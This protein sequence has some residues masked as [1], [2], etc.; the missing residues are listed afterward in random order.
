MITMWIFFFDLQ[1]V[2]EIALDPLRLQQ[3]DHA[4]LAR[5]DH[6][7]DAHLA[8]PFILILKSVDALID[9]L[10]RQQIGMVALAE[11]AAQANP[12]AA[13]VDG[14]LGD[15]AH[16]RLTDLERETVIHAQ[17]SGWLNAIAAPMMPA[18]LS[19]SAGTTGACTLRCGANLAKLLLSPPPMMNRSG[20]SSFSR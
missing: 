3:H 18:S 4:V 5:A 16:P 8:Q 17:I 13:V 9:R 6:L 15:E 20:Q 12:V 7:T 14:H 10:L 19:I 2:D 11:V 1:L